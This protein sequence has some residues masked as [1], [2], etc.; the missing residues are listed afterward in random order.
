ME[1]A[2]QLS[3]IPVAIRWVGGR[4][5][6]NAHSSPSLV[7]WWIKAEPRDISHRKSTS[8]GSTGV[9]IVGMIARGAPVRLSP[10]RVIRAFDGRGDSKDVRDCK[11]QHV[12]RRARG[13]DS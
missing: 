7:A 13:E 6:D 4:I 2:Y 10:D 12:F 9:S 5:E 8:N 11:S 1:D 3:S